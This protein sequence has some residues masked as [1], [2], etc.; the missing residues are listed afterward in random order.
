MS[1]GTRELDRTAKRGNA[2]LAFALFGI[3]GGMVGLAFASAP[4]YR[5]FC[6]VT[7]FGGT[8]VRAE[9][10]AS[11]HVADSRKITVRFDANINHSLP[12]RFQPAQGSVTVHLGTETLVHYVA[13]NLSDHAVVGT[14]TFNV[15]PYKAAPYF[16]K[17]ECFCFTEQRLEPG[18]EATMPVVF[19]VDPAIMDDPNARDVKTITLSYTFFRDEKAEEAAPPVAAHDGRP[20]GG[21]RDNDNS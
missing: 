4:L 15:T 6:Q 7:G 11:G 18:Q 9:Q 1:V 8:V 19:Y 2:L 17:I 3:V 21:I 16:T 14:A 10:P 20:E 5:L 13:R 12:W